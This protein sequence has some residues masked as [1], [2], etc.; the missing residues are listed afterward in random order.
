MIL[1]KNNKEPQQK[2][3][4][5]QTPQSNMLQTPEIGDQELNSA[6]IRCI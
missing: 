1:I 2:N 5:P 4:K 3:K 6:V